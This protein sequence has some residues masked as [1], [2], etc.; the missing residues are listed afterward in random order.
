MPSLKIYPIFGCSGRLINSGSLSVHMPEFWS[1]AKPAMRRTSLCIPSADTRVVVCWCFHLGWVL[2]DNFSA[3]AEA[4]YLNHGFAA[5]FCAHKLLDEDPN[6]E[7][8]IPPICPVG[9]GCCILA[10]R[11]WW[12]IRRSRCGVGGWN[13]SWCNDWWHQQQQIFLEKWP[14]DLKDLQDTIIC[15]GWFK[16]DVFW[17]SKFLF[18]WESWKHCDDE[19]VGPAPNSKGTSTNDDIPSRSQTNIASE[20]CWLED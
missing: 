2:S 1:F 15:L 4:R 5:G 17:R 20:N 19:K 8:H 10:S 18:C 3:C 11:T 16:C 7:P 13:V 14:Q 9:S 6:W 12:P